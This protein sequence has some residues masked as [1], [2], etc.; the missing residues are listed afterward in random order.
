MS[1]DAAIEAERETKRVAVFEMKPQ[2][3]AVLEINIAKCG[4]CELY[5]AYVTRN[6]FA[7][8]KGTVRKIGT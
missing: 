7:F 4:F 5:K 8:P 2:H 3:F 6:K 1:E